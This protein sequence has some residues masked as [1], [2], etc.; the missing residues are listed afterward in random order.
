M[1]RNIGERPLSKAKL[2][3]K[4]NSPYE[5]FND[6]QYANRRFRD[7]KVKAFNDTHNGAKMT[8]RSDEGPTLDDY[9]YLKT[10]VGP[11][12]GNGY[13]HY[14]YKDESHEPDF[15]SSDGYKRASEDTLK[16]TQEYSDYLKGNYNYKKGEGWK[17]K[18]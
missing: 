18:N 16:D 10:E 2:R 8:K 6:T 13:T 4:D 3:K 11:Y 1:K 12:F 5:S 7:A 9:D 15:L 17:L 14:L